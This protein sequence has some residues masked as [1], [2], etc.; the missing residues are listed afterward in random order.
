MGVL[1][2]EELS[3]YAALGGLG[4]D[5]A[6]RPVPCVLSAAVGASAAE[7]G[8][9][10]PAAQGGGAAWAGSVEVLAAPDQLALVAHFC[11][12]QVLTPPVPPSPRVDAPVPRLEDVA[13]EDATKRALK[14]PRREWPRPRARR[15][16]R[17]VRDAGR[18]PT[19]PLA[20]RDA[21]ASLETSMVHSMAGLLDGGGLTRRPPF[22]VVAD[23]D[24]CDAVLFGGGPRAT[25]PGEVS[26]ALGG[27]LLLEGVERFTAATLE[28]CGA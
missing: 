12:S 28:V 23:A 4:P 9:V 10:C 27:V 18:L 15:A 17:R 7:L 26:L 24:A 14:A 16:A 19:R 20:D 25:A 1:P 21:R 11:G 22:R 13:V 8:L 5:G 6:L 2:R 3:G